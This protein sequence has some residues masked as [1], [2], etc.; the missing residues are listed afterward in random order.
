MQEEKQ[1]ADHKELN[2]LMSIYENGT[3]EKRYDI[4]YWSV[5]FISLFPSGINQV[6]SAHYSEVKVIYLA[7]MTTIITR[8]IANMDTPIKNSN[9][10]YLSLI[11]L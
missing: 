8:F 3:Y 10:I 5:C 7:T 6:D 4:Q 2:S 1:K 11:L 9:I